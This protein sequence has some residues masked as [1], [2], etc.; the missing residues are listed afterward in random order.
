[1]LAHDER[2]GGGAAR[3]R[4]LGREARIARVNNRALLNGVAFHVHASARTIASGVE[5][6]QRTDDTC[7]ARLDRGTKQ[8]RDQ[9]LAI[10]VHRELCISVACMIEDAQRRRRALL[11]RVAQQP[12]ARVHGK[13]ERTLQQ[14]GSTLT[15]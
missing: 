3:D 6:C 8:M 1:V 4:Q 9:V 13:L 5:L 12:I 7:F 14:R 15:D 2:R 11:Y 10:Q